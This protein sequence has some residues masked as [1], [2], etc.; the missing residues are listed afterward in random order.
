MSVRHGIDVEPQ[1]LLELD[2]EQ[3]RAR[4]R[5]AGMGSIIAHLVAVILLILQPKLFPSRPFI[6]PEM[7]QLARMQ[8]VFVYLPPD[9]QKIEKPPETPVISD[10]DRIAVKPRLQV[11][12]RMLQAPPAPPP[13]DLT[14]PGTSKQAELAQQKL[15]EREAGQ[16]ARLESPPAARTE[17]TGRLPLPLASAGRSIEESIRGSA[18]GS[19]GS[20]GSGGGGLPGGLYDNRRANFSTSEPQILSDTRGVD[21]GPYL[22]R[23]LAAVRRNWYAVIPES[24]RLGAKGKVILIFT[25][26]KDGSLPAL[27]PAVTR[28]SGQ[29]PLDR[30]AL[31]AILAST[32]FPPLPSQFTGDRITLQFTFLYNLPYTY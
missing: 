5:E 15:A 18:P 1:F 3:T 23:V 20:V 25:I 6:T 26:L 2:A 28:S 21:F 27:Q 11:N 7:E 24:A 14:P 10:K 19:P 31:S 8:R 16:V 4:W 17:S 32:P 12:P 22:A 30:A 9:T 13:G 29:E